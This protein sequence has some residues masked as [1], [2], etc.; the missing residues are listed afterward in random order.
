MSSVWELVAP[1]LLTELE[2]GL[3]PY[4]GEIPPGRIGRG[5]G[6]FACVGTP[7]RWLW[8]VLVVLARNG[9][10]FPAW[11]REV[12]FEVENRPV[13][14]TR[15]RVAISA[16]RIFHFRS[17]TRVMVDAITAER[18]GTLSDYLGHNGRLIVALNPTSEQGGLVLSSK[19]LWLRLFGRKLR[20]PTAIAPKV[21]I[22]ERFDSESGQQ[23]VSMR[24]E[25]PQLGL[26]YEYS[27][28][29]SYRIVPN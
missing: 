10:V 17:G 29:F 8:P 21:C 5:Q 11:E 3:A 23:Q 28:R 13:I 1:Q 16:R 27:G 9:V 15:G 25:Q 18:D 26:L 14:D 4:F 2:P 6:V 19:T 24:L 12:S 22:S 7:R 20:I